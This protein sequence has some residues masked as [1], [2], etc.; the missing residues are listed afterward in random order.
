LLL[1]SLLLATFFLHYVCNS[2]IWTYFERIGVS[3]GMSA[4]ESGAALGP[5]MGAGVLGMLLASAMGNRVP[6]FWPMFWGTVVILLSTLYLMR[7]PTGLAFSLSTALFS[8]SIPFVTPYFVAELSRTIPRGLGVLA[9]NIVTITGFSLGPYLVS[10][11]I[12][13]DDFI[14]SVLLTA[15][16]F[17]AVLFLLLVY[18]RL[19]RGTISEGPTSCVDQN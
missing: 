18:S 7:E 6:A 12:H 16:G 10:L 5:G 19:S 11:L 17:V 8:A 1:G 4:Q 2:G 15:V 3:F 13:D 9:A 14:P